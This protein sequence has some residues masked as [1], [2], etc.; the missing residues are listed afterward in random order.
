MKKIAVC[1]L[2]LLGV[3]FS[4]QT[5]TTLTGAD[6]VSVEIDKT[7][8]IITVG[9]S[10]AETVWAL[11]GGSQVIATDESTTFPPEVFRMP[12]VPYVRNLTSEGILSLGPTLILASDDAGPQAA[13]DQIRAVGTDILLIKEEESLE[14]VTSK[15]RLIG[16]ILG[17]ND[18]AETLINENEK[19]FTSAEEQRKVLSTQPKVMF[20]LSVR[21]GSSFMVAGTN[22]GADA[23]I[24]LAGGKNA[25]DS[26]QGYKPVS[27]EAILAANPDFVLVMQSRMDEI[28]EAI[29]NTQGIN[30]ISA[31]QKNQ[32]IGMDGNKLLG[33]G[34]R[35]GSA[36]LELMSL[37]HPEES[38]L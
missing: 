5:Q 32:I 30:L 3:S 34:P 37:L 8:R 1:L 38:D 20:V 10:I 11:G 21:N 2:L 18:L 36:I 4:A 33:F 13:I 6:G 9:G 16:E 35:F 28:S 25:M 14:G 31:S 15:I 23:M 7:T 17:A 27:N 29:N 22:T 26:F 12:R 24:N 19:Q